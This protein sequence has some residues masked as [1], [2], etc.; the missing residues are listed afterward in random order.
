[1]L[2]VANHVN[3]VLYFTLF[4]FFTLLVLGTV[5][6]QIQRNT[7]GNVLLNIFICATFFAALSSS[8]HPC[9]A[10]GFRGLD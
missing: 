9:Y 3:K 7:F 10:G 4:I 6:K 5:V 2:E 1:M 8:E